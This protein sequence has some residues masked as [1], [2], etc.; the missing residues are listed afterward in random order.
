MFWGRWKAIATLKCYVQEAMAQLVWSD[1]PEGLAQTLVS[2]LKSY[3]SVIRAPP[4][5][6]LRDFLLSC[7]APRM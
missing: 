4:P 3:K 6:T 1:I 7:S 5:T 2:R